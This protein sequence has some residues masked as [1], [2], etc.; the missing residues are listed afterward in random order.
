MSNGDW[1]VVITNN[2]DPDHYNSWMNATSWPKLP[3]AGNIYTDP[4]LEEIRSIYR[5][6]HARPIRTGFVESFVKGSLHFLDRPKHRKLFTANKGRGKTHSMSIKWG[7]CCDMD[8]WYESAQS[9]PEN[10]FKELRTPTGISLRLLCAIMQTCQADYMKIKKH[11][12]D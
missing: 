5:S 2:I 11:C 12:N 9:A 3:R 7:S 8:K 1:N 6:M 10:F 4:D